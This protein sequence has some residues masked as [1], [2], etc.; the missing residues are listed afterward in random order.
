MKKYKIIYADPPWKWCGYVD[1]LGPR[2]IENHYNT[3]SI[4]DMK[5]IPVSELADKNSV[6]FFWVVQSILP[7]ALEIISSWGFEFKTVAFAWVKIK[8]KQD[9]LFYAGEDVRMGLGY[10]TRAGFEQCW[11]AT[12]GAGYERLSKGEPQVVF[13]PR[14]EHSRKPDE[15]A[16]AIV[17]LCGD[18]PRLEMFARTRRPGWDQYGNE[19]DKFK[20]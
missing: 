18:V 6:L 1:R 20:A 17:R 12:R 13:S 11:L 16:D 14:R 8:G 2:S 4:D 7:P 15:I 5:L 3:M 9:R 10:H 19:P